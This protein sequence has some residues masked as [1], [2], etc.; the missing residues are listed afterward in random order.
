MVA[1]SRRVVA[2]ALARCPAVT[3]RDVVAGLVCRCRGS[4]GAPSGRRPGCGMSGVRRRH[5]CAQQVLRAQQVL[6]APLAC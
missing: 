3:G 5:A 2:G 1:A 6:A 4:A